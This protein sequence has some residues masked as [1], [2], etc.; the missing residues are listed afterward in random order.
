MKILQDVPKKSL[1]LTVIWY[2]QACKI[3]R[4]KDKRDCYY[5]TEVL[6]T[7]AT[8]WNNPWSLLP[9]KPLYLH[10]SVS[11]P[12]FAIISMHNKI[13]SKFI[14]WPKV[15]NYTSIHNEKGVTFPQGEGGAAWLD[16]VRPMLKRNLG[17]RK[18]AEKKFGLKIK[19]PWHKGLFI[20]D[21]INFGGCAVTAM[22]VS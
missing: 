6:T 14:V 9:T 2:F 18:N 5:C 15:K 3:V 13:L 12:T 21:V 7:T 17:Q 1:N 22:V 19:A 4:G 11:L 8:S 20:N 10:F 16:V